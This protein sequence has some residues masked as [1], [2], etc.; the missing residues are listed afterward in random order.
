[1][2]SLPFLSHA[3]TFML[4]GAQWNGLSVMATLIMKDE[5]FWT[6]SSISTMFISIALVSAVG[7]LWVTPW[8]VS[9]LGEVKTIRNVSFVLALALAVLTLPAV[10][11]HAAS[12]YVAFVCI[13]ITSPV[14]QGANQIRVPPIAEA[15]G[16]GPLHGA[17][18]GWSRC[19]GNG[20]Q[21]VGPALFAG[22]MQ[23]SEVLPWIFASG[24]ALCV[25][26]LHTLPE[27]Y[28]VPVAL[29]K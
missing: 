5:F 6:Q 8:M 1:M 3:L 28:L 14:L 2:L 23:I 26:V 19:V 16:G 9:T 18:M 13:M 7:S 15:Y 12:F 25:A 17:L 29:V 27:K 24:W 21:M 22:C 20:G 11:H 10:R 4:I